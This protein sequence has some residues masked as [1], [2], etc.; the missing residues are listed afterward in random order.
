MEI[1]DLQ[2]DEGE[3]KTSCYLCS[4]EYKDIFQYK[5][6]GHVYDTKNIQLY[7]IFHAE[8]NNF[9]DI[10]PICYQKINGTINAILNDWNNDDY[11][12]VEREWCAI[13]SGNNA[14]KLSNCSS[15]NYT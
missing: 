15:Y 13:A 2:I 10:C 8:K 11:D 7:R 6:D 14:V 1:K 12:R 4:R 9:I 5:T 3:H